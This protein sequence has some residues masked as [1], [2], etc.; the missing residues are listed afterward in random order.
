MM[1]GKRKIKRKAA[2]GG[3]EC[4]GGSTRKEACQSEPCGG[5]WLIMLEFEICCNMSSYAHISLLNTMRQGCD[6]ILVI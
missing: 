2:N 1:A 4:P 6:V 3:K 5:L